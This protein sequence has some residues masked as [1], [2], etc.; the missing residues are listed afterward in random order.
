MHHLARA[1]R[2]IV[3]KTMG[4]ILPRLSLMA[5]FIIAARNLGSADFGR[6]NYALNLAGLALVG[7][8]LGLNLLLIREVA[9]RPA[10]L[11]RWLG[12]LLVIKLGLAGLIIAGLGLA[13]TGLGEDQVRLVLAVAAMQALWGLAELGAAGLSASQ[14]MDQEALAKNLARLTALV[15]AG[16]LLW[17]GAGLWGLVIGLAGGNLVAALGCLGLVRRLMP[18]RVGLDR[19]FLGSLIKNGLPLALT[20][21][22]T[23]IYSR[24][25]VVM[26]PA[27]GRP[28]PEVGWYT[29]AVRVTDALAILAALVAAALLPVL[30]DLAG[31]RAAEFKALYR[32]GMSLVLL[33]G[34]PLAVGLWAQR[35]AVCDL[36]YG[37]GYAP[38]ASA[39]LWLAP[40]L[41]LIFIN[42]LQLNTLYALGRQRLT[43]W[44]AGLALLVN[45]LLNW[46]LIP[47]HGYLAAA[48]ATLA[49]ELVLVL[50]NA[51]CLGRAAGLPGPWSLAGRPAAATAMM[52]LF[53]WL[54]PGWCLG[55]VIPL[56][57]AVYLGAALALGA[58][59]PAELRQLA[60]G[61]RGRGGVTGAGGAGS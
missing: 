33:L 5:L 7:M 43:A 16:A 46:L 39:F 47:I 26:L 58:L 29:A 14:R 25:D 42:Y 18:W 35:Q 6:F 50:V 30:S 31:R 59:R 15:L 61:W 23:L 38:S 22:F 37:P 4:E 52:G 32:Q 53:L 10:E 51:W 1:G 36:L 54:E 28:W 9:R 3:L 12:S 34:L 49:G 8:D 24:V 2:N 19:A 45:V 56:A 13:L 55:L 40:C 17:A 48:A 57:A 44:S 27:L 11:G 21:V 60:A 20:G 41:G